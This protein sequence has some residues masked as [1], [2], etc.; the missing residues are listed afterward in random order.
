MVDRGSAFGATR[1][2]M[3]HSVSPGPHRDALG[4]RP[5]APTEREGLG[6]GQ[7]EQAG[8]QR[9]EGQRDG[10]PPATGEPCGLTGPN[11][12]N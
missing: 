9:D 10:Q 8:A 11:G 5:V 4:G 3:A 6:L 1:S 12:P 7:A 2:A